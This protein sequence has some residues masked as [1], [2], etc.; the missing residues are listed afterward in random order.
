RVLAP[1]NLEGL[2]P[3]VFFAMVAFK[4][5]RLKVFELIRV[6]D[7]SLD[8]LYRVAREIIDA[9]LSDV[10]REIAT[11]KEHSSPVADTQARAEQLRA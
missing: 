3:T 10:S 11:L 2:T 8:R 4:N 5:T 1:K 6:G 9:G 7:S